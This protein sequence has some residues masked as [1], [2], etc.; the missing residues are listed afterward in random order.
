MQ[1]NILSHPSHCNKLVYWWHWGGSQSRKLVPTSKSDKAQVKFVSQGSA[2]TWHEQ[3]IRFDQKLAGILSQNFS[4]HN[5]CQIKLLCPTTLDLPTKKSAA[6]IRFFLHPVECECVSF[7]HH[8][9]HDVGNHI[10][11]HHDQAH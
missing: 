10:H 11:N 2:D 4:D 5:D 6:G 8:K 9:H 1:L 7:P 3:S